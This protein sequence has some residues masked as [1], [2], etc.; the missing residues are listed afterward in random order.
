LERLQTS[1]LKGK[2]GE[3][4]GDPDQQAREPHELPIDLVIDSM[5][6]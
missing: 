3:C 6:L 1:D 4:R 2:S 5:N